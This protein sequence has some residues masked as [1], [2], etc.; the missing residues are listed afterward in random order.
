MSEQPTCVG[1][2]VDV[3]RVAIAVELEERIRRGRHDVGDSKGETTALR[4]R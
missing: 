1:D 2:V 4:I 3:Y